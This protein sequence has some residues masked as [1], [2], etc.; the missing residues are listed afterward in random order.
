MILTAL[1]VF[2]CGGTAR[3]CSS[4]DLKALRSSKNAICYDLAYMILLSYISNVQPQK[5][6]LR[7]LL[8]HP[9]AGH[10]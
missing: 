6:Y 1:V 9:S 10:I 3:S 2:L 8:S 7:E 4:K 5:T